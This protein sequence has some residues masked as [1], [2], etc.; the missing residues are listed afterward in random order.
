MKNTIIT[1]LL[2]LTALTAAAQKPGP[3]VQFQ[4]LFQI[5][6]AL[7][8]TIDLIH[9]AYNISITPDGVEV[10]KV[11]PPV[12]PPIWHAVPAWVEEDG[13]WIGVTR[14][15]VTLIWDTS[16]PEAFLEIASHRQVMD[17]YVMAPVVLR[18]KRWPEN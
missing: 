8:D 13:R 4:S 14:D 18:W 5:R 7:P 11:T 2:L 10:L 15:G 1:T 6:A 12:G 17:M 9:I 16:G 3:D